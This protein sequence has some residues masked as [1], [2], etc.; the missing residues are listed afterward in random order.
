MSAITLFERLDAGSESLVTVDAFSA[1]L[2]C[3]RAVRE[4]ELV[5]SRLVMEVAWLAAKTTEALDAC[6]ENWREEQL[7][8]RVIKYEETYEAKNFGWQVEVGFLRSWVDVAGDVRYDMDG[9]YV[10]SNHRLDVAEEQ[11]KVECEVLRRARK[12]LFEALRKDKL[13]RA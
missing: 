13:Q 8:R 4:Q 11:L 7:C 9:R 12:A 10:W 3:E 1:L 5:V 2:G 6:N